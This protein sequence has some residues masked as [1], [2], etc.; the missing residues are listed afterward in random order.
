MRKYPYMKKVRLRVSSTLGV[1]RRIKLAH[2]MM[3]VGL[4]V[5][6]EGQLVQGQGHRVSGAT[7]R[8]LLCLRAAGGI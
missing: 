2:K 7:L 1:K 3:L 5:K 6:E 8:G 4:L